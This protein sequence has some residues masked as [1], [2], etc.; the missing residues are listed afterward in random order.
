M[1]LFLFEANNRAYV[2]TCRR[3]VMASTY[4]CQALLPCYFLFCSVFLSFKKSFDTRRNL[5]N[6][7]HHENRVSRVRWKY[8]SAKWCAIS[9]KLKTLQSS[10]T[11]EDDDRKMRSRDLE[12][13]I[14]TFFLA[15]L[16]YL[17]FGG[18]QSNKRH[19][20]IRLFFHSGR[21]ESERKSAIRI[22]R[23]SLFLRIKWKYPKRF[24]M[25]PKS[26]IA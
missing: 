2:I 20:N 22:R 9:L 24:L 25:I 23:F 17:A 12:W 1:S 16:L 14:R 11:L 15:L 18:K 4:R 7:M 21:K 5:L 13:C 19:N 6:T 26:K 8:K 10:L 3:Q